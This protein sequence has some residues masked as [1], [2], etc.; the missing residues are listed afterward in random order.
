MKI[1]IDMNLPPRWVQ[2]FAASGWEAVHWSQV[3]ATNASDR[4][5]WPGDIHQ[6]M[7]SIGLRLTQKTYYPRQTVSGY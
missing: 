4:R 2:V 6:G 3:G 7:T 1:L 5:S